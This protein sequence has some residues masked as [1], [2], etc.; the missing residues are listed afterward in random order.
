MGMINAVVPDEELNSK[1]LAMAEKLAQAPTA[2]IGQIK[3][4][5]E[6]SATS[7][8]GGQLELER[9]TQIR[10]GQT[11]D[12]REGVAAFLEKRPPKFVGK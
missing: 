1:A 10:S 12:F 6:R 8:Y 11:K 7:D 3:E 9:K 2:A 5:L 4:L